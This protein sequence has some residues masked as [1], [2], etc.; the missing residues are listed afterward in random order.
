MKIE[1]IRIFIIRYP[2]AYG[3]MALVYLALAIRYAIYLW[4]YDCDGFG[5]LSVLFFTGPVT[6][7]FIV[8]FSYVVYRSIKVILFKYQE[9]RERQIQKFNRMIDN[10][11][12]IFTLFTLILMVALIQRLR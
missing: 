2:G 3:T 7:F 12:L 1:T 5:C 9:D 10:S 6:L 4:N 11:F 8:A